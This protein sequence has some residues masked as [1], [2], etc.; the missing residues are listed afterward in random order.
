MDVDCF[1]Y[2]VFLGLVVA[3]IAASHLPARHPFNVVLAAFGV[4]FAVFAFIVTLV[5]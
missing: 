5:C 1:L 4:V 3:C 2:Q